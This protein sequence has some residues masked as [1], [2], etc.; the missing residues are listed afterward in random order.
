MI[1][2]TFTR[3]GRLDSTVPRHRSRGW[4]RRQ[5]THHLADVVAAAASGAISSLL[6]WRWSGP[7][8]ALD[9]DEALCS[10]HGTAH[11]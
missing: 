8:E 10:D 2:R 6:V 9:A 11:L 1:E 7:R 4:A 3:G 5:G